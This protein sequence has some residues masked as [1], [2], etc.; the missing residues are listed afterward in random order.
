MKYHKD[1][2]FRASTIRKGCE[3][4]ARKKE[5]KDIDVAIDY[6]GQEVNTGPEFVCSVCHRLLFRKQVI[7]CKTECYKTEEKK[8]LLWVEDVSQL[9][10]C[11]FVM[12]SVTCLLLIPQGANYGFV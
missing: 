8:L 7:E 12:K 3:I 4:Y 6:F 10:I 1:V 9:N 5:Q 2:N 11:M